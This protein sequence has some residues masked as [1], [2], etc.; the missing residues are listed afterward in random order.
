M[1]FFPKKQYKILC[2]NAVR[3]N[4][5]L[6]SMIKTK[7]NMLCKVHVFQEITTYPQN[8]LYIYL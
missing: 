7:Q 8:T 3:W 1:N 2:G 4:F 6:N 5:T